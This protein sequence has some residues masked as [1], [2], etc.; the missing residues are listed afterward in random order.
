MSYP[1]FGVGCVL[2]KAVREALGIKEGV[3]SEVLYITLR[4]ND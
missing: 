1:G 4:Y 3:Y 2:P